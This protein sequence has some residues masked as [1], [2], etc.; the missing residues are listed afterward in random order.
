[1]AGMKPSPVRSRSR[2]ESG[3]TSE[4]RRVSGAGGLGKKVDVDHEKRRAR[5][6]EKAEKV[7]HLL[8]W[9]PNWN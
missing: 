4:V 2:S 9:G 7:M 3:E 8:C 5:E 6:A 1:M